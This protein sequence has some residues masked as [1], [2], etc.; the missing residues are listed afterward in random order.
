MP[1]LA[2]AGQVLQQL[3]DERRGEEAVRALPHST[4]VIVL[5]VIG[6]V[7]LAWLLSTA[8][9]VIAFGGF[10][11]LRDGDRLRIRRGVS[12]A[13]RRPS[14]SGGC[15]PCGWSRGSSGARSG[16]PR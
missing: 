11:V 3:F 10:T 4:M 12:S 1:V 2:G 13:A 14:R 15:G 6:I 7:V 9:A 16:W 8:G 5:A